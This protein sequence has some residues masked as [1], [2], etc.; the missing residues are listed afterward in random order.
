[1]SRIKN[2]I[3]SLFSKKQPH[4]ITADKYW[5]QKM[6]ITEIPNRMDLFVS[7]C[8]DKDVLH[9]GCTDWPVFNA[10]NN[11]HIKLSEHT[12]SIDGFDVDK[13]G[14]EN[15][16]QY[17]D[18][19]YYSDFSELSPKKYDVCLIPETIEHV[20][21]IKDFLKGVSTVKASK[22]II[23]GPNCFAEVRQQNYNIENGVFTEV[24]HPDHNAWFSPFTLKNVIE[25]YSDL[26]VTK[27]YL[28]ENG[29]M[30][31]CEAV[32]K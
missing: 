2:K 12:K 21:N 31:C 20:D 9:F 14:I 4:Y 30:V 15:L 25:K 18:Q 8:K 24:V 23:T 6:D 26:T 5:I 28:L 13:P 19:D 22:F 17:V 32:K 27:I 29:R 10:K 16:R 7:A 11:L 3:K 1:M